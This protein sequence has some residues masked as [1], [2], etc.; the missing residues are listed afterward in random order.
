MC[1]LC[2]ALN[3]TPGK[4]S[5]EKRVYNRKKSSWKKRSEHTGNQKQRNYPRTTRS[6]TETA[7][8]MSLRLT[9]QREGNDRF[10]A[11]SRE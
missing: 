3:T 9:V 10:R 1:L 4:H 8:A 6:E 5:G 7:F 2:A 11:G